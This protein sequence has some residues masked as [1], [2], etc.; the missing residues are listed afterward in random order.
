VKYLGVFF[1][2]DCTWGEHAAYARSKGY[3]ALAMWKSVLRNKRISLPAKLA[4]ITACI[5]PC[6][7]YGMEVWAPPGGQPAKA[8][9][10]PLRCALRAALGVPAG[11]ARSLYP[12]NLMHYDA[13]I[14]PFA[15]DNRA[16]H[17]RYWQRVR[18][19]PVSRL[20]HSALEMLAPRHPWLVRVKRWRDEIVAA[21]PDA[22]IVALL[23][24]DS[25]P[26]PPEQAA[27]DA[28][29]RTPNRAIN[30]GVAKGDT[31]RY[32]EASRRRG[33][34]VQTLAMRRALCLRPQPYLRD[35]RVPSWLLFRCGRFTRDPVGMPDASSEHPACPDCGR[36]VVPEDG[37][38]VDSV[39]SY[40]MVL[41]RV[42]DCTANA[43]VCRW[44]H[45]VALRLV[46]TA[47][48]ARAVVGAR[49]S[50]A[51]WRAGDVGAWE[52]GCLP[53]LEHLLCPSVLCP[54][55][56]PP[57][58]RRMLEATRLFLTTMDAAAS[59]LPDPSSFG[60][61]PVLAFLPAGVVGGV[62]T[63]F[64]DAS[65]WGAVSRHLPPVPRG[66]PGQEAEAP[67][68]RFRRRTLRQRGHGLIPD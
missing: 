37:S 64:A 55:D 60:P 5:K 19:L 52:R 56:D 49:S 34:P 13:A 9:E 39:C 32:L 40:R 44:Y 8:L 18:M 47:D 21:D 6:V 22:P 66:Q 67:W 42:T 31:T 27:Q 17:V 7:T 25:P 68:V 11:E 43:A 3:A 30:D 2:S 38:L 26:P 23:A 36:S 24:D 10:T 4:V 14:R 51:L 12:A 41:H 16:A 20:Q 29:V 59:A 50:H 61:E 58:L 35:Q 46:P 57:T 1:T 15:S 63:N 48:V 54:R 62:I 33:R 65:Y 28:P 45:E 53:F